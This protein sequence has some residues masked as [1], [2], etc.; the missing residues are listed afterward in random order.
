MMGL[1]FLRFLLPLEPFVAWAAT[2]FALFRA[3]FLISAPF[4]VELAKLFEGGIVDVHTGTGK[5][6]TREEVGKVGL[7][8]VV[9]TWLVA[10]R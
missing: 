6:A 7:K 8:R 4:I 10:A 9:T 1:R 3:A 5:D 2:C